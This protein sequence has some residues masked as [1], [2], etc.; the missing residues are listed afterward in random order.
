MPA[1]RECYIVRIDCDPPALFHS[2]YGPLLVPA[3]GIIGP[4][5]QIA[6]GTGQLVNI[7]DFQQL[8][9]GTAE[10]LEFQLSGV[11][12]ETIRLAL[13]DAPSVRGARVDL[14]RMDFGE[15]WQQVGS[16]V[17]EATFEARSLSVGRALA[18][19]T[20]TPTRTLTLTIAHGDTIRSR[21]PLAFFTD[22]DQRRRSP[23][24]AVFSH[25]AGI[26]S[27]TS[28]RFGPS[29]AG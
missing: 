26:N 2:G 21:A 6:L 10:R 25:V 5:P 28:R 15:D 17:W 12:E 13:E 29:D 20:N 4:D 1:Y 24:D 19:G 3:D 11:N 27:G 16:V 23:D 8:I 22:S 9:N 18:T 14:G 7:P